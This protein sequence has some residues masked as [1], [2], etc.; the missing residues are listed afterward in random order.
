MAQ[1]F[2]KRVS[3]TAE[4]QGICR[5]GPPEEIAALAVYFGAGESTFTT[6]SLCR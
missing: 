3:V 5:I 4:G 2:G 6:V 1:F